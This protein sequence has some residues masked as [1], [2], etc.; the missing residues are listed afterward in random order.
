MRSVGLRALI[1]LFVVALVFVGAGQ[2]H[3]QQRPTKKTTTK[4]DKANKLGER[5]LR[6]T[7]TGAEEDVMDALIRLMD[8]SAHNL[9]IAFDAG[10]KTQDVQRQIMER[11]DEAIKVAAA[12]RRPTRS[13]P[14]NA[15]G[16]KRKRGKPKKS[17]QKSAAAEQGKKQGSPDSKEGSQVG[18]PI[19]GQTN[20]TGLSDRRRAWG[21]LPERERDEILQGLGDRYLE[22]Y[23]VWIERYY[24]AL[25]EDKD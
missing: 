13:K 25:Q 20:G 6:K 23:R 11:L 9:D 1:S 21:H 19:E 22:R 16:D 5:L 8:R 18:S 15:D 12:Q 2:T 14:K 17:S 7:A 10:P 4:K 3:A 24:K